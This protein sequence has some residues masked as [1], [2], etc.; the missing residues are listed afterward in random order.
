MSCFLANLLAALLYVAFVALVTWVLSP[1]YTPQLGNYILG[2]SVAGL[3]LAFWFYP[4]KPP[5]GQ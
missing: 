5:E 4:P 3:F 2:V 1:I